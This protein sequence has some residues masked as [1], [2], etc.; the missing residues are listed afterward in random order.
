MT[1][2]DD[3]NPLDD[4][5]DE[6]DAPD[7]SYFND[8]VSGAMPGRFGKNLPDPGAYRVTL[9]DDLPDECFNIFTRGG[10][11]FLEV[12]FE[13]GNGGGLTLPD[14]NN[15]N[16]RFIR[17]TNQPLAVWE[18]K[19]DDDGNKVY[20]EDGRPERVL[21]KTLNKDNLTDLLR[22]LKSEATPRS[23]EEWKEA[24]RDVCGKTTEKP[25]YFTYEGKAKGNLNDRN[26]PIRL[27]I[28]SFRDNKTKK[29]LPY[30]EMTATH[31]FELK[32]KK[33]TRQIAPGDTYRV[34][35]NLKVASGSCAGD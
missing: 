31:P 21:A 5:M 17:L 22:N 14:A 25:I 34:Y 12:T 16:A 24:F 33:G 8:Y 15:Y 10:K 18:D 26:Y 6:L 23:M 30:A 27:N 11:K 13:D 7:P 9:P 29:I 32:T 4:G 19:V 2:Y 28:R 3:T 1:D 35:P 20:G